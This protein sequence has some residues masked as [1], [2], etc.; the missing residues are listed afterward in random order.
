[1]SNTT[2]SERGRKIRNA[3]WAGCGIVVTKEEA[4]KVQDR[5]FER[6]R[7]SMEHLKLDYGHNERVLALRNKRYAEQWADKEEADVSPKPV[8]SHHGDTDEIDGFEYKLVVEDD[9]GDP[10]DQDEVMG[11]LTESPTMNSSWKIDPDQAR[12][13]YH[14]NRIYSYFQSLPE[15]WWNP[16]EEIEVFSG[17][18]H[19]AGASR[20]VAR[21]LALA[22]EKQMLKR[23]MSY[24]ESWHYVTVGVEVSKEGIELGADYIG[25]VESDFMENGYA[26]ELIPELAAQALEEAKQSIRALT[27]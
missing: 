22:Q 13:Y 20:Q 19:K 25:G 9:W 1:M 18:F 27:S 24:G 2:Q 11:T 12:S 5:M 10:E 7:E 15:L 6:N 23:R 3:T 21:E 17:Y 8:L 14:D 26:D 16:M 4:K